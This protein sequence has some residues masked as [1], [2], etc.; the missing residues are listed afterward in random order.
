MFGY[1]DPW[2][3]E[4]LE[5]YRPGGYHP[6]V[7]DDTLKERY[8]VVHKL[9]H[10]SYSTIWL[11]RDV[12]KKTYVTVKINCADLQSEQAVIQRLLADSSYLAHPGWPKIPILQDH[13][14][15]QSPNGSHEC[16]VTSPARMSL[17]D[18]TET[19]YF[20]IDIARHLVV[21]LIH[22]VAYVHSRGVIHG[23]EP[24]DH[25]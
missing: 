10:G 23:G 6:I 4:G 9:G 2:I 18:A 3:V 13:F 17:A 12:L 19:S 5:K 20:S 16:Y 1:I 21:Q 11:A 8:H 24:T 7:I 25:T 22:A 15:S 14:I